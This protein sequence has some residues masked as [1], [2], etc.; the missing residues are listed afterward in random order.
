LPQSVLPD[1]GDVGNGR[2]SCVLGGSGA[3]RVMSDNPY[4]SPREQGRSTRRNYSGVRI[5]LWVLLFFI[6]VPAVHAL[7]LCITNPGFRAALK[8]SQIQA[9]AVY[10]GLTLA[11]GVALYLIPRHQ[12]E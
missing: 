4:E 8:V 7:L 9:L 6:G 11:I 3:A 2:E 12:S 10:A 1:F 5:A